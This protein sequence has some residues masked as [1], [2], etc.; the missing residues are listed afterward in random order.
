MCARPMSPLGSP[1]SF[2][3]VSAPLTGILYI[4]FEK[5]DLCISS[6]EW[7]ICLGK[8]FSPVRTTGLVNMTA[9]CKGHEGT[10]CYPVLGS[11]PYLVWPPLTDYS[12]CKENQKSHYV[13]PG[14][15]GTHLVD[16]AGSRLTETHSPSHP[17]PNWFLRLACLSLGFSS[18]S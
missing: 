5:W 11:I 8:R 12:M 14:C 4:G 2:P 3:P 1:S 6:G 7:L 16:E 10:P 9:N 15:P 17:A 13:A 18:F